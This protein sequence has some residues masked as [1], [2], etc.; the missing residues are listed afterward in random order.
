LELKAP[1]SSNGSWAVGKWEMG[2]EEVDTRERPTNTHYYNVALILSSIPSIDSVLHG[3][4]GTIL[5][6][7]VAKRSEKKSLV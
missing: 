2:R 1:G 4:L 7:R 3:K 5:N 6:L